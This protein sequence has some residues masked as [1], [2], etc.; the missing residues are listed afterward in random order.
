MQECICYRQNLS[1]DGD[2]SEF[3]R[4]LFAN[5]LRYAIANTTVSGHFAAILKQKGFYVISLIHDLPGVIRQYKLENQI[6]GIAKHVDKI[7][8]PSGAGSGRV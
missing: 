3:A 4:E 5:G 8:F 2:N 1:P 7:I 6:A